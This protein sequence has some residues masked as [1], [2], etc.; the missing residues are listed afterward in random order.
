MLWRAIFLRGGAMAV[1]VENPWPDSNQH[2]ALRTARKPD[3]SR[4]FRFGLAN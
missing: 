3:D 2:D 1:A 4:R